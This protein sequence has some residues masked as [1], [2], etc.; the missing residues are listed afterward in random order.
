MTTWELPGSGILEAL[1]YANQRDLDLLGRIPGW[2]CPW[3]LKSLVQL[4]TGELQV[5]VWTREKL[6]ARWR[7][8]DVK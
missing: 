4:G 5:G 6:V 2:T 3:A 8:K 7:S 1:A